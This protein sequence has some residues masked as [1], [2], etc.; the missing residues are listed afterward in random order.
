MVK[1]QEPDSLENLITLNI[2]VK[3]FPRFPG[4]GCK[5]VFVFERH[6]HVVV[7]ALSFV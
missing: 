3:I 5:D 1:T 2:P 4:P 7:R 6:S